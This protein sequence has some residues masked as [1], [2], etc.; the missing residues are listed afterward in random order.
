MLVR[1]FSMPRLPL[2]LAL[3][4]AVSGTLCLSSVTACSAI[5]GLDEDL[6][7]G[8]DEASPGDAG[9][10]P[11]PDA[12]VVDGASRLDAGESGDAGDGG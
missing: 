9:R 5:L 2:T 7:Q 10:S 4:A 12:T 1:S 11:D 8:D 3:V 6:V